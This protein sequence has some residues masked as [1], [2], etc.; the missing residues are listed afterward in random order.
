MLGFSRLSAGALI[1]SKSAEDILAGLARC[2]W[3]LGGLPE[4]LVTDREGSLHAGG[5]RPSEPFARFCGELRSGW[6][7]CA[8]RDAQ[9][10]GMIESVN[11][12]LRSN[13]EPGRRFA[14]PLDFEEQLE[15]WFEKRNARIHRT[16]RCRPVERLAEEGLRPLPER[17]PETDR[18]FVTR[19]GQDPHVR[20]DRNDYSLDPDLVGRRVEVRVSQGRGLGAGPRH[21]RALRPPPALLRRGADVHRARARPHPARAPWCSGRARSRGPPPRPLR[22]PDLGVSQSAELAHLFRALKAPAAARALPTLAERARTEEWSYER[23]AEALLGT[24]ASAREAHGGEARIKAARF[25]A[26]KTLEEFDFAWPG[27]IRTA[28][29]SCRSSSRRARRSR[30]G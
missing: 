14:S 26:H 17:P 2:L 29:T 1:F 16:L 10:K 13:F 4:T 5:G 20:V 18:R 27:A 21:R 30:S 15:R 3:R 7:I 6:S 22:R 24:E 9:A 23:F 12:H 8:P 25:P 28:L 11:G 19:V